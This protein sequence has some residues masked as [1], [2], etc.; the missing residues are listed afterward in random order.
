MGVAT[1]KDMMSRVAA[2]GRPGWKN[3]VPSDAAVRAFRAR[4]RELTLRKAESKEHAKLYAENYVHVNRFFKIMQD[5]EDKHA[6]L[7]SNPNRIVNIDETAVDATFG[8]REKAFTAAN[9]HHGGFRGE[10][11]VYGARQHVTAVVMA[12]ASGRLAPP[13]F[14]VEGKRLNARW[15]APVK[16]GFGECVSGICAKYT[17]PNWF[18]K[19]GVIKVADNGSMEKPLLVAAVKHMDKF[20][21]QFLPDQSYVLCLDGHSSRKETQWIEECSGQ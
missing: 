10:K 19:E 15:W 14:I 11:A 2:D 6:G 8:K 20:V 5:L 9:S 16:G 21:R 13:F 3:S 18:P 7:L 17:K 4:H 12:T 1:V